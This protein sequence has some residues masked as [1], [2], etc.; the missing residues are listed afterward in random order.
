MKKEA[1]SRCTDCGE[2]LAEGEVYGEWDDL[3][4]SCDLERGEQEG[5]NE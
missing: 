4:Q 2:D 3:C 1:Y 5:E